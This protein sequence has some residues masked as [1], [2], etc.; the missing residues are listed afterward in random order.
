MN[1]KEDEEDRLEEGN[2]WKGMEEIRTERR[3]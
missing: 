2:D 1:E 3:R